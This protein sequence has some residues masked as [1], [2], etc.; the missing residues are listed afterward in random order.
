MAPRR[1][2]VAMRWAMATFYFAAGIIH[3]VVPDSFVPIVPDFVPMPH[4]VVLATGISEIVG[5]LALL[6]VRL[7]RLA[8]VMLALYAVC[9]FPANI[10]HAVEGI[11]LPPVPDSWWYHAPRLVMQPVLV[12]W[13]LF[14]AGVIDWPWRTKPGR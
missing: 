11:H 2:R 5:S 3:L 13:A 7:R 14:C 8:G 12:W 6:T 9:V 10:K 1:L 4:E